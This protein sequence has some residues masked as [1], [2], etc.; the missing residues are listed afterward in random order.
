MFRRCGYLLE[1]CWAKMMCHPPCMRVRCVVKIKTIKQE[2]AVTNHHAMR[3]KT[4][5]NST[6]SHN[7]FSAI[8]IL[9]SALPVILA[10]LSC[11]N[12]RLESRCCSNLS[13]PKLIF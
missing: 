2:L 1:T 8:L 7:S 4:Q 3:D 13:I 9:S 6:C 11:S 10:N 12:F 5:L